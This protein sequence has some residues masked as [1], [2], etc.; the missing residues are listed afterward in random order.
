MAN[1]IIWQGLVPKN[2]TKSLNFIQENPDYDGK[3]VIVGILDTG[4]DPGAIGL[5]ETSDGKPKVIDIID[6]TGSGDI[7]MGI[8][9]EL[10]DDG[11]L[12]SSLG[13]HLKINSNLNCPNGKYRVGYKLLF[14]LYPKSLKNRMKVKRKKEWMK[15]HLV[16]EKEL[17]DKKPNHDN[18]E[19]M[20]AL[21]ESL[22]KFEK[23]IEDPGPIIDCVTYYDG[24]NWQVLVDTH[25]NGDMTQ[26]EPMT[27]YRKLY[28][29]RSFS[30]EDSF[31][32]SVNIFDNGDT[33]SINVDAGA[34]GTHVAGI[35]AAN[36][37]N[38]PE[39]NGVAPGAQI[40]GLKIGDSRLGSME[41]GVGLMR[42]LIEAVKRGCHVINMSYGEASSWD[43]VGAIVKLAE[44]VVTEHGV[45]FIGSA[46]NNGPCLST[47]G[48]PCGTSSSIISIGAFSVQSLMKPGYAMK[49]NVQE[50]NYTWSSVGPTIDGDLG[51]S[52]MAP[53]GAVTCVPNWTQAKNQLMN[54]TSMS[55][56]NASGCVAL[57][58]S[59]ALANNFRPHPSLVR[60]AIEN[61]GKLVEDVH[62][63]GQGHG[64]V[65]VPAAWDY[66]VANQTS[67]FSEISYDIS[68]NSERFD[69]GIYLKMPYESSQKNNYNV[70]VKPKFQESTESSTKI[71]FEQRLMLTSSEAWVKCPQ[72]IDMVSQ[73]KS[74]AIEVDPRALPDN[75]V[76]VAFVRAYVDN[77]PE[78]GYVFEV[79]VTVV[80]PLRI[81]AGT[82]TIS[83]PLTIK[84][85]S[86]IMRLK[87][88]ERYRSFLVPPTGCTFIEMTVE[89]K[90]NILAEHDS[91]ADSRLI[92]VA[93][94]QLRRGVPYRDN[95]VK[96]YI[97]LTP[98]SEHNHS[99]AVIDNTALEFTIARYWSTVNEPQFTVK[100]RFRGVNPEPN[101]L[102]LKGGCCVSDELRV[103]S[104]GLGDDTVQP[105]AKLNKYTNVIKPSILGEVTSLGERDFLPG[106]GKPLY[107]MILDYKFDVEKA[108]DIKP[109]FPA[110]QDVLYESYFH[111]QL[112]VVYDSCK[113]VIFA[114]DA[115]PEAHNVKIPG[116]Y[117]LKLQIRHESPSVFKGLQD[118]P[119]HLERD[120]KG[121]ITLLSF[122][123][124]MDAALS[125]NKITRG[126]SIID[127]GSIGFYFKEPLP[128]ALPK[129]NN[130]G[131]YLTGS[132]TLLKKVGNSNTE[133]KGFP[134][135]YFI[136]NNST[137]TAAPQKPSP[138]SEA[139]KKEDAPPTAEKSPFDKYHE[140]IRDAKVDYCNKLVGKD[141]FD[142]IYRKCIEEYPN[143]L[144][145][146]L[147]ALSNEKKRAG[148]KPELQQAIIDQA[149]I[150]IACIDTTALA[151]ALGTKVEKDDKDA[152]EARKIVN[153]E[154]AGLLDALTATAFALI[155]KSEFDVTT[156]NTVWKEIMKWDELK[157]EKYW[158]I[159]VEKFK[160][161]K[162]YGLALKKVSEMLSSKSKDVSKEEVLKEQTVILNLLG[163]DHVQ[164]YIDRWAKLSA[165]GSYIPF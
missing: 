117:T 98:G 49:S 59:A 97:Y 46:G 11:T 114:G 74:F 163:W 147:I 148:T 104:A 3:G 89:D 38:N 141:D 37:P 76:H 155:L 50:T 111:S 152:V 92:V 108:E 61:T 115:F 132:V 56:P 101:N 45:C 14:E 58:Y 86:D 99:F 43:N 109:R 32:F 153:K 67:I 124:K 119:M 144:P 27:D 9:Q 48:A 127:G 125:E 135:T 44:K 24:A 2:E 81:P 143:H 158:K 85:D 126:R 69:R 10:K 30:E 162:H 83:L 164:E 100:L 96:R 116:Q 146:V 123:S 68:L 31:N 90:R 142:A 13:Y 25:G 60:K 42:A 33:V 28:Q 145:L 5:Q 6:C 103:R 150:V 34:H 8:E 15:K 54:G 156:F 71:K 22:S 36:H 118:M 138:P 134:I 165:K 23:E 77:Q 17:Y 110:L 91:E 70:T 78:A 7:K 16:Y 65:Q 39:I 107:Q 1:N 112:Y 137:V 51:V 57:L 129:G 66:L 82:K 159:Q 151:I 122:K 79:P 161:D 87:S 20:V 160:I 55:A 136:T 73:G 133:P 131:D 64:L 106:D 149:N 35:V 139:V 21:I 105:V 18:N 121:T 40:V 128:D 95:E 72:F 140:S 26:I 19:D 12:T 75:D 130:P 157:A 113:K 41:T 94:L 80:R 52:V 63:L 62:I 29:Y 154:K 88:G 102:I 120:L 84:G 47:V 53:G 93:G 4:V